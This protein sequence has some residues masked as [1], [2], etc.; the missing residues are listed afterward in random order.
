MTKDTSTKNND[1]PVNLSRSEQ[2]RNQVLESAMELFCQNGFP[3]TSMDEVAKHA[4]VSKQ[5][6]YSH[7]GSKD[8]LFVAAIDSKCVAHQLTSDTL[9]DAA[10][11]QR[12][13]LQFAKQFGELIVSK[14]TMTVF[15]TCVAQADTHPEASKLFYNAGPKH[16]LGLIRE[17][18]TKVNQHGVYYFEHPHDS[19]V[20]L[21]LMLFGELKL[22]LELALETDHLELSR[23][24]YL[25]DTAEMFLRAHKVTLK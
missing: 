20:R 2:K 9:M 3:L 8:D 7:F 23:Q 18:L 15:K 21:C 1:E 13:I 6:V 17:Y 22:R 14:D 19:A 10:D 24:Q 11:P 4:G 12:V 5:T 25:Q 16:V